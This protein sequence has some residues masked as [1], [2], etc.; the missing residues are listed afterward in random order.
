VACVLS[1]EP[2]PA[3]YVSDMSQTQ[4]LRFTSFCKL[5]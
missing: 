5:D 4:N 2:R 1:S 3:S